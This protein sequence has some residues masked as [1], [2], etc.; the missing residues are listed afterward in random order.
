M[1]RESDGEAEML[2]LDRWR[3]GVTKRHRDKGHKKK[4]TKEGKELS[5]TAIRV[6]QGG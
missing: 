3:V 1:Q 5:M 2:L 4:R 6:R